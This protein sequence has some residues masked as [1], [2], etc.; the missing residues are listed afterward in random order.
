MEYYNNKL[1]TI[2]LYNKLMSVNPA[3]KLYELHS[4]MLV[5]K[6]DEGILREER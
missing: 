5:L 2:I 3:V 6:T 1:I 4:Y